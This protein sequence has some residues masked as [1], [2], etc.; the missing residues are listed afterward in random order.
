MAN[1]DQPREAI[2][3][4]FTA[5]AVDPEES[6]AI[7]ERI[8]RLA[9]RAAEASGACIALG[10][11]RRMW[12][13]G[14][15]RD[16]SQES[17]AVALAQ[18]GVQTAEVLWIEDMSEQRWSDAYPLALGEADHQFYAAAPIILP[19]G[20]RIG[21][22]AIFDDLP[23]AYD[24]DLAARLAD[25]AA[26]VADEWER[27]RAVRALARSKQRLSLATEIANINVWEM[28][29]RS[30]ELASEG[31]R[32]TGGADSTYES[33]NAD[34]W[35]GVHPA[36]R[37][38]AQALWE[39]HLNEGAPYRLVHR[40]MRRD[41]PHYWVESAIEAIKDEQGRIVRTVGVI[42]DI[43]HEKRAELALAKA[44]DDAEAANRA[45]SLFLATM[46]H[47][48]RTPLN[49]VL[50]MAQAM[51][52]D[53]LT[54]LQRERL[55][56]VHASGEALLAIL[57]DVLDLAKIE[58]GKLEIEDIEFDLDEVARGAHQ[59]FTAQANAKGLS[60]DLDIGDAQGV[61]R[62]DP[63]RL[64]QILYN[65]VSNALKF[66]DRG[67]IRVT[68]RWKDQRLA[69]A[70]TDT[71]V[72]IPADRLEVLFNRFDQADAST[73]RRF[74]GTGLGLAICR[75]LAEMMGGS[76][77]VEST[78]GFGST[79]TVA[80][81]LQ[82]VGDGKSSTALPAAPAPEDK[83]CGLELRV[84]AAED[85]TVNQLVLKT[86][87][88]QVGVDPVVVS[89][90]AEAVAAW[91]DGD[92]DVILMDVQMPKMDGPT[93]TRAIRELELS[94]GRRRTPILAL[95]AN[96]MSHQLAEYIAAGMDGHV[97]KPIQAARLFEAL[98][99]LLDREPAAERAA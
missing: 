28:D 25:H 15:G 40:M 83:A 80:L 89:N 60:F 95:T 77:D 16:Q 36:D 56:V 50:G 90:G 20:S 18:L 14:A 33:L 1:E 13:A 38:R 43:D 73:T 82:R 97:A 23:R 49:G 62:G 71:G 66:T 48:I 69:L 78:L 32:P 17:R 99:A 6:R 68:A 53:E 58:A 67:E 21:V 9:L 81:P 65:L 72:G 54:P 75:E 98:A 42:R 52:M 8:A 7:F 3:R 4:G 35:K 59:A 64:R 45:K 92:W 19:N 63:T 47:E 70:V 37:E 91:E 12:I 76:I 5:N 2:G 57:N 29:Y 31:A 74:G 84:L 85:N 10:G 88:H 27:A 94:L 87:L 93:A 79:F 34:I 24:A 30:R 46:S 96:V 44:R 41:G 55:G 39:R 22:L 86:L 26:F 61:Y 51:A 11:R